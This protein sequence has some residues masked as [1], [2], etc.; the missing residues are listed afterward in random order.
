MCMYASG[1]D[2]VYVCVWVCVC[3]YLRMRVY[4]DVFGD[5]V[6]ARDYTRA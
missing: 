1:C 3:K 5:R 6:C 4:L 2:Y